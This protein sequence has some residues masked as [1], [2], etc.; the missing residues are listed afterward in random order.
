MTCSRDP[1]T[2]LISPDVNN[3]PARGHRLSFVYRTPFVSD[4]RHS[5][6][7]AASIRGKNSA[8]HQ[9]YTHG[10]SIKLQRTLKPKVNVFKSQSTL[11]RKEA[12]ST[13]LT[14]NHWG[15]NDPRTESPSQMAR[16]RREAEDRRPEQTARAADCPRRPGGPPTESTSLFLAPSFCI[17]IQRARRHGGPLVGA[18]RGAG[19]P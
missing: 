1:L 15:K 11:S 5:K 13:I 14:A 8:P 12:Y 2:P 10:V 16:N 6:G 18:V 9:N 19:H 3:R 4:G 17:G 7:G